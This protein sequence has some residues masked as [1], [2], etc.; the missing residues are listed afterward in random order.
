ME[1][2]SELTAVVVLLSCLGVWFGGR[3]LVELTDPFA[4]RPGISNTVYLAA[5]I[6]IA[7]I[8]PLTVVVGLGFTS[9]TA[10]FAAAVVS[11]VL[12]G[13]FIIAGEMAYDKRLDRRANQQRAVSAARQQ[14]WA[15]QRQQEQE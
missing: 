15:R 8:V 10:L 3:S 7:G 11:F 5:S 4:Y 12:F 6:T 9:S 1:M 14:R 13:V 2:I